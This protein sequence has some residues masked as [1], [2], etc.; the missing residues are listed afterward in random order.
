MLSSSFITI[1]II[2][3]IITCA[4][5]S[6]QSQDVVVVKIVEETRDLPIVCVRSNDKVDISYIGYY[7]TSNDDS[8]N[9]E[10]DRSSSFTFRVGDH[11]VIAGLEKGIL[12]TCIGE[13]RQITFPSSLGY[14]NHA[15]IPKDSTLIFNIY[16]NDINSIRKN[17][18]WKPIED[19]FMV[20]D[21][22]KNGEIEINE[23]IVWFSSTDMDDHLGMI[24]FQRADV[25]VDGK[26]D[27]I[28]YQK[29]KNLMVLV[30]KYGSNLKEL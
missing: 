1:A 27:Q 16:C 10:F 11:K 12:G 17:Q 8:N 5:A 15:K 2:V 14:E 22:N 4:I 9:I 18:K 3:I 23:F 6:Q 30:D 26:I 24:H 7:T 19:F 29:A 13:K 21:T 25:N 28:E 20:L